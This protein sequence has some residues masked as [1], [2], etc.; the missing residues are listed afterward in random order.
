MALPKHF[1]QNFEF[2]YPKEEMEFLQRKDR[3]KTHTYWILKNEVKPVD[4]Y[5]YLY[6]R[7]G[8]PNGIQ[9]FLRRP[10]TTDNL[11]H[12]EWIVRSEVGF[13]RFQGYNFRTEIWIPGDPFKESDKE[14]FI[15]LLKADFS[16]I[17]EKMGAVRKSLEHWVEF[18]NPYKR[19]KRSVTDLFK[20]L[21][22][23]G[24][25]EGDSVPDMHE[26][27]DLAK[28]EENWKA[29]AD[30]YTKA[31]GLCFGIRSMLPVMAESFVNLLLYILMKPN[32]KQDE[33]LRENTV[34]Q[35]IDIRI[36][37]LSHNCKGFAQDVDYRH[38]ACTDFHR[39][40]NERN[41]LLHGNVVLEKLQFNEL[42]F[43]NT[44][45]VF[46]HYPS[47]WERSFGVTKKAVG[48][49]RVYD[50]FKIV[51]SFVEYIISCLE[52]EHRNFVEM[53]IDKY[54]L[55]YCLDDGRLGVL[56]PDHLVDFITGPRESE[57]S[58]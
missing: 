13:V 40:I 52:E 35:Q 14:E 41:D 51:K 30:K 38:Q 50:E 21:E 10:D 56:F 33:R 19:I 43:N 12:W 57:E 23:L 36:R 45:P 48:L 28:F 54:D 31:L 47:M 7:F 53:A 9:N 8:M 34:R 32:L 25:D 15:S 20:E 37:S 24:I 44:V 6:A 26:M 27:P 5:C 2:V 3:P 49:D 4:L 39:L 17:G 18:I 22:S 1:V 46:T 55:G 29:N 58:A 42:Y 11:I 16:N